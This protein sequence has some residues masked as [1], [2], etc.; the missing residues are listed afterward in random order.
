VCVS[1]ALLSRFPL[2]P[3]WVDSTVNPPS[4]HLSARSAF[5]DDSPSVWFEAYYTML[6]VTPDGRQALYSTPWTGDRRLVDLR[7]KSVSDPLSSSDLT[8]VQAV[9][10]GPR[11][12]MAVL[13]GSG[14]EPS[15]HL[16]KGG[17]LERLGLPV[18]ARQLM[19]SFDGQQVALFGGAWMTASS[20]ATLT[21]RRPTA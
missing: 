17:R 8:D 16:K 4:S 2:P 12:T 6:Q 19:W 13:G 10:L 5:F 1:C 11:G 18:D 20:S 21:G 3:L 9:L 7:T 15:W 14:H